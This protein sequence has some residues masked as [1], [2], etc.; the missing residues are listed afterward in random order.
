MMQNLF[1]PGD[2]VK[3]GS[4]GPAM[5]VSKII[6][7]IATCIWFNETSARFEDIKIAQSLLVKQTPFSNA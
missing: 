6:N 5:T 4:G 7:G 2:V 3:L 1:N